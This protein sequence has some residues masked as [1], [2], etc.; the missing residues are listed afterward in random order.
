MTDTDMLYMAGLQKQLDDTQEE[1]K[2]LMK[3]ADRLIK[4]K[5]TLIAQNESL[6]KLLALAI[7]EMK[8]ANFENCATCSHA[9][10]NC[11]V[12]DCDYHWRHEDE[13]LKLIRGAE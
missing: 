11:S 13:A 1:N 12:K 2:V 6:K 8:K 4:E 5:G 3:E 9:T 7:T 10:E